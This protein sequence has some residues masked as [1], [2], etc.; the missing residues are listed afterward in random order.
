M[1]APGTNQSSNTENSYTEMLRTLR[2][3]IKN[4][5]SNI[6]MAV[7]QLRYEVPDPSE[8]CKF[9]MDSIL[10]SSETINNLLAEVR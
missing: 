8:D 10:T 5:L 4:Q 9:Y 6:H 7:E 3:D 2:H 1:K